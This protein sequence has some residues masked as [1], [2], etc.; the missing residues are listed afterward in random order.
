[1]APYGY[2]IVRSHFLFQIISGVLLE[3]RFDFFCLVAY[4]VAYFDE[5]WSR[6]LL[7]P[8]LE[9]ARRD[10]ECSRGFFWCKGEFVH[11]FPPN[12]CLSGLYFY[13]LVGL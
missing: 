12:V 2:H 11:S 9:C 4:R 1:M 6:A 5:C 13:C 3:P 8:A 7:P 10:S